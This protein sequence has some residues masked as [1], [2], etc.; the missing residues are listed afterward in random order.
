[1]L[2]LQKS[3]RKCKHNFKVAFAGLSLPLQ[4]IYSSY[5]EENSQNL[6]LARET[7]QSYMLIY[8]WKLVFV[9]F[10]KWY[11]CIYSSN[12]HIE[13]LRGML[14]YKHSEECFSSVYYSLM[15]LHVTICI[16]SE[17]HGIIYRIKKLRFNI[18]ELWIELFLFKNYLLF[19]NC[20]FTLYVFQVCGGD[21]QRRPEPER[22]VFSI[23]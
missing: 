4:C 18:L 8:K 3:L 2:A 15:C 9:L 13:K 1:M 12:L 23:L 14:I 5:L 20:D 11:F 7:F 10:S 22:T 17:L 16:F 6:D 21:C 19:F